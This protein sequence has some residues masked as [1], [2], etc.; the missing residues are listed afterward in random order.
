MKLIQDGQKIDDYFAEQQVD[1]AKVRP[2]ADWVDAVIDRF[3]GEGTEA[4]WLPTGFD[5]MSGKFDL[6]PGE[7]T[8]WAGINKHGKTTFLTNIMLNVMA[9]GEKVCIASMEM[10]PPETMAK[11]TRQASGTGSP[12]I[13]F[14]RDFHKWTDSRLWI[15][16]HMGRVASQRIVAL[17]LY[18]RNQMGIGHLV[19]DSLMKCGIGVEDLTAQ[20]DFVD[21]LS[22]TARDTGLHIHLVCHMRKGETEKAPP[23]KF[24]VKGAGEIADMPDNIVIV[25]KN[26]RKKEDEHAE[27]DSYVRIAGQRHHPWEGSFAFWFDRDSQQFLESQHE[28][29]R[30]LRIGDER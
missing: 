29:P 11:M 14:I 3:H 19:I 10:K 23:D 2:A 18:V 16:D 7:L 1:T 15:Y 9:R 22:T 20:K 13:A 30:Y 12:T 27:P 6:R 5:K 8:V 28:R 25:W 26:L 17:A 21:A 4:N 24:S